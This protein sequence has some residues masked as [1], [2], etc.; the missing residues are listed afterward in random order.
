MYITHCIRGWMSSR[1][2]H[3][4]MHASACRDDI[5][6]FSW[7]FATEIAKNRLSNWSHSNASVYMK[8]TSKRMDLHQWATILPFSR[9]CEEA[10]LL[11]PRLRHS[12]FGD[13]SQL[14]R[15]AGVDRRAIKFSNLGFQVRVPDLQLLLMF[16][17][18]GPSVTNLSRSINVKNVA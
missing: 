3:V 8:L 11:L 6:K 18:E 16:L 13:R 4:Q 17:R 5:A 10:H 9:A 15:R 7:I 12:S 14:Q 1:E 2:C